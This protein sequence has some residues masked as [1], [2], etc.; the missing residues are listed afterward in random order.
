MLKVE[1]KY[2]LF[3]DKIN[4]AASTSIP[5]N[6]PFKMKN[7]PP[8]PWWDDECEKA[9]EKRK[10]ALDSY[11]LSGT[12]DNFV[13]CKKLFAQTKKLFKDKAKRNWKEWC[14]KL[15]KNTPSTELW[16][17]AKIIQRIQVD[18]KK[19]NN[20]EW[21]DEFFA[22]V[23]PPTANQNFED[24]APDENLT[25][26]SK[27]FTLTE[28]DWAI[29]TAN[30]TAPG[31]DNIKYPMLEHLSLN[32]KQYLLEI[33]NDVWIK[34]GSIE[35]WKKIIVVPIHKPNK[36]PN[37]P[38]SYR[39]IS[40]LSCILKTFERMIKYRL[41]WWL[42]KNNPLPQNQFGFK[43]GL[44]T[45]NAVSNIVTDIQLCFSKN[46]YLGAIFLD[47]QGAY[48]SVNLHILRKKLLDFAIP[49]HLANTITN[50][51]HNR[52]LYVRS[53]NNEKIGPRFISVGL[54]QGSVLSPLL[55]N[56]YTADIHNI[57][58]SINV[59]QY[60]DDFC[61]YT[62]HRK[63][64]SCIH[65]LNNALKQYEC[66][67]FN[68]GFEISESKSV[69]TFF[70]RHNIHNLQTIKFG[71]FN[72]SIKNEV[73]YLGINLDKK[74]T[75]KPFI[76]NIINKCN[77]GTNFLR[78]TTK[79]WWGSDQKSA[80]LF[81]HSYI[82]SILD[83]GSILYS[84]ASKHLL[85]RLNITQNKCLRICLGAMNSTPI[86][87]LRVEALE[88]PL[89]LRRE[90]LAEKFVIKS[91]LTNPRLIEKVY[92]LNNF[93]LL[94]KYWIK[95]K[96]P[97]LCTAFRET[98]KY[99]ERLAILY[100]SSPVHDYADLSGIKSVK[101]PK[102]SENHTLNR[103]ILLQTLVEIP[104]QITI[105]TDASKSHLGTGC[106]YF[107]PQE[108]IQAK[109]KLPSEM[110]IFSAEAFAILQGIQYIISNNYKFSVI[111]TD[112]LSVLTVIKNSYNPNT[113]IDP[114]IIKIKSLVW[115]WRANGGN[116]AFVWVKG[117]SGL[118]YNELVDSLAKDS[119][120]HGVD[121]INEICLN[122][123]INVF[124]NKMNIKWT[125]LWHEFG[126]IS[127]TRYSLIQPD[128]PKTL[129]H[130]NL[131]IPRK[132]ISI[133]NRLKFGHGCY[134]VHLARLKIINS[135]LC[136][137]CNTEGDLDHIIFNCS[138]Y[139]NECNILY[140]NLIKCGVMAPFN[141]LHVLCLNKIEI[142]QHLIS[143]LSKSGVKI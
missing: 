13:T 66:W 106:A 98:C 95:K 61:I 88:P 82:R 119:V 21:L 108:N 123:C 128:I 127:P 99:F 125:H 27:P 103:S 116:I 45:L 1:E 90:F 16:K 102:Y 23:S 138:A 101:I 12:Y 114:Y 9:I 28:L 8:P 58:T 140:I 124:K 42:K 33:F 10:A 44:G 126:C 49:K 68:N 122:D 97:E 79:T 137:Y 110:S 94:N 3:T 17:Q 31:F 80:L 96:S 134:P 11:K 136:E 41:E 72:F 19:C 105:Y 63:L 104:Y 64:D 57:N 36:D 135:N 85:N 39:P 50:I 109:Y 14:S 18:R 51:L 81:Y 118:H 139:I 117:H 38:E 40:L 84:S 129:W 35:T 55:F 52:E 92:K 87:P 6:K 56:I 107:I 78:M 142:I 83:Y 112:S 25:L 59:I 132:Y 47:I 113:I 143:F 100:P 65:N 15:N 141:L 46:D 37:K 60:A 75:W 26:L 133:I 77:K 7:R 48:D 131:N 34:N 130:D 54:P 73:K 120:I 69:V 53:E 86:E 2:N 89:Q 22:N 115:E 74:L 29:K 20:Y 121:I 91:Q 71:K 5:E 32:A 30:N 111:L 62:D 43:Q 76:E 24:K 4:Q 70:S 67:F 93:D